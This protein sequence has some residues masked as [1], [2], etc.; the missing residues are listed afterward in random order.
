MI[1]FKDE[2]LKKGIGINCRTKAQD[3][4]LRKWAHIKG[5]KWS[6]G[7]SYLEHTEWG[8]YKENTCYDLITGTYGH[9]DHYEPSNYKILSYEEAIK[10]QLK[11]GD[12]CY[13]SGESEEKALERKVKR[14]Y[15]ANIGGEFPHIVVA[16]DDN[17]KFTSGDYRGGLFWLYAVPIPEEPEVTDIT[18]TPEYTMSELT[19][20]I[21][22]KFKLIIE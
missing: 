8:I 9:K 7:K 1:E 2:C 16:P 18:T 13:V 15:L 20:K 4:A 19:E 22:H 11:F 21:G 17:D 14:I 6:S 3:E 5:K 12:W 10:P